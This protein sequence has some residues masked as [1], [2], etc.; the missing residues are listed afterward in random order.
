MTETNHHRLRRWVERASADPVDRRLAELFERVEPARPLDA[1]RLTAV[2]LRLERQHSSRG[3]WLLRHALLLGVGL[4]AGTGFALANYGVQRWLAPVAASSASVVVPASSLSATVAKP[5][6]RVRSEPIPPPSSSLAAPTAAGLPGE[7][8]VTTR[9]STEPARSPL[10]RETDLLT[11]ALTHLRSEGNPT[12]A[13]DLLAQYRRE[14]PAGALRLES[15]IARLDA[16]MALGRHADALTLLD[17][18]PIDRIGRGPELRVIRAELRAR[19]DPRRA[20]S[21]FD[22]A[23]AVAL[24]PALHERAL[25]GRGA[26]RLHSGDATGARAD[27]GDYLRR[28]PNGRFAVEARAHTDSR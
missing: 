17:S 11:R 3:P 24:P 27:L 26:S 18:L 25:F 5:P 4:L 13:L 9:A 22:A 8:S 14:F 19:R 6:L 2:R 16:F 7:A 23:L 28:Y 20:V 12:A 10:G 15:D 1:N 21:D